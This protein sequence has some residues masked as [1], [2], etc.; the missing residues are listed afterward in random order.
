M[1]DPKE[2]TLDPR[3]MEAY[4]AINSAADGLLVHCKY[5]VGKPY[6]AIFGMLMASSRIAVAANLDVKMLH[7]ALE[8]MYDDALATERGAHGEH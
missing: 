2:H 8:A 3:A 7:Q 1:T 5:A 4:E 6:V